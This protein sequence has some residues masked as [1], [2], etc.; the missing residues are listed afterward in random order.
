MSSAKRKGTRIEREIVQL[1][2]DA[3]VPCKRVPWSG[4]IGTLH[5]E[6]DRL[7]GD[8]RVFPDT[9]DCMVGEVKSRAGGQG[10]VTLERWLGDND[11]LFLRR[12]RAKPLVAMPFEVYIDLLTDTTR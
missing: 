1:H 5:P 2:H 10:F 8:V 11:L 4:V 9:E 6:F 3:G 7:K 12:D